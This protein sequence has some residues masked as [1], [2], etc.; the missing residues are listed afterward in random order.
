MNSGELI[1]Y[2][3]PMF[4]GKCLGVGT[5]V[6]IRGETRVMSVA[7]E[8]VKVG[9]NVV[10]PN[11]STQKVT[12]VTS[13]TGELYTVVQSS[14]DNYVV[15]SSH[16]LTLKHAS[17]DRM[18]DICIT[19]YIHMCDRYPEFKRDWKGVCS[20]VEG[21][22][23][24]TAISAADIGTTLGTMLATD[25]EGMFVISKR[26]MLTTI[27]SRVTMLE[28]IF[29]S[30]AGPL[31]TATST[32]HRAMSALTELARSV[33]IAL[34]VE[35][36]SLEGIGY[37][38]ELPTVLEYGHDTY[39]IR[40]EPHTSGD[41]YGFTLDGD[42]RF[43]LGDYTI[44]HNTTELLRVLHIDSSLGQKVLCIS[45]SV[46]TRSDNCI[47]THNRTLNPSSDKNI[48][49]ISTATLSTVDVDLY[50]VIGIDEAQFFTGLVDTVT[51]WV[52]LLKKR[53][54]VVGLSGD[55]RRKMFG[56]LLHLIPHADEFHLLHS[57][58]KRCSSEPN[59]RHRTRAPFTKRLPLLAVSSAS[60][61]DDDITVVVGGAER[62]E[63]LCRS[64]YLSSDVPVVT[65][66]APTT[67]DLLKLDR[68]G[69]FSTM[70]NH[71]NILRAC[72][73]PTDALQYRP[74][75]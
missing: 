17:V 62:Y 57:M 8:D 30:A 51:R 43:L 29:A 75:A 38:M 50:D 47:S 37:R 71:Y 35:D 13:G 21:K 27:A 36:L 73:D 42:G 5:S 40:V 74:L 54:V 6:L 69:Y 66:P 65:Q 23:L 10:S 55:H 44:T 56:E 67:P 60:S 68:H 34:R 24:R 64:C 33:G 18:I 58:C 48:E 32:S 59:S 2:S 3:G 52:D 45:H 41:Y 15:N 22:R 12:S 9:D 31:R 53:V 1:I 11:G 7:V 46:D 25:C 19:D 14:G 63:T 72:S 39:D 26:R 28:A 16:I 70:A 49:Y 20:A 61:S 4:S